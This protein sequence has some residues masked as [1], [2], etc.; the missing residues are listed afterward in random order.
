MQILHMGP[1]APTSLCVAPSAI[2]SRIARHTPREL[3]EAGI[4]KQIRNFA[5]CAVMAQQAGYD[6]VEIIGSAGYLISTFLVQRTNLRTD[7]WGR[8]LR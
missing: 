7:A 8:Q 3:D 4:Q 2:K 5:D 6:G 1:L